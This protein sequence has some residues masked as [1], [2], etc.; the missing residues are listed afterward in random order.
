MSRKLV[1]NSLGFDNDLYVIQDKDMFNYSVDTILLGN[2]V[3]LNKSTKKMLEIGTNNGA[4]SI[5]IA[6]RYKELKIDALEIQQ[7]AAELAQINVKENNL[8]KQINVINQDFNVFWK[9]HS[10]KALKKYQS[11]VC[12]PP[13][14]PYDKSKIKKN[15]SQ[16][17]LIATHEIYLNLDQ[18]FAGSSKIIEQ[19]GFITLVLPVERLVDCFESMRK[20]RFEPKRIQFIYPRVDDKPKFALIEGRYNSG[21]GVHFLPN[22]YLHDQNDKLNHDYLDSIKKLYKPIKVGAENEQK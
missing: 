19:K 1:K 2:Y 5:F 10:K 22:L 15:I 20:H 7:K 9:E 11:I 12:N 18:I 8:E 3:F 16:E 17:K 14:Y 4:L 13:F 6:S 21:W